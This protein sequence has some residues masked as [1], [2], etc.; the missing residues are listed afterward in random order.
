MVTTILPKS[1]PGQ[2]GFAVKRADKR[3][4]LDRGNG[5]QENVAPESIKSSAVN[6]ITL[7][8]ADDGC[9]VVTTNTTDTTVV[10]LPATALGLRFRL[11]LGGLAGAGAG[12]SFSPAAADKIM[13]NG[14]TAADDK[15]AICS[16]ATDRIGDCI[17]LLGDGVDGWYVTHVTGTWAREA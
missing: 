6:A 10:T 3:M 15:D 8:A 5:R 9:T 16:A 14:F 1:G 11:I 17:E 12:H 2:V 4:H 13:G 7:T